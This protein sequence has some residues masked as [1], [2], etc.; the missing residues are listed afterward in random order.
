MTFAFVPEAKGQ[1]K[2]RRK[3][4]AAGPNRPRSDNGDYDAFARRFWS[5]V[6]V[7][8]PDGCW[9]WR[10]S[11]SGTGFKY[12]QV[13]W[14]SRY[15]TPQKAH[16]L[17]WELTAGPIPPGQ[18]VLHRCDVPLCCNPAHLFL[19]TQADNVRDASQKRRLTVART[20]KLTLP[21]RLAIRRSTE[22]GVVLA[23]RYGVSEGCISLTRR[24]RF[25]GAEGTS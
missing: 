19:G 18:C 17:A 5:H 10:G 6:A 4:P 2:P 23:A 13:L 11:V 24:G 15:Q 3:T 20:R 16:R 1:P 8:R 25:I 14:R 22:P 9:R 12:G 7:G 21:D